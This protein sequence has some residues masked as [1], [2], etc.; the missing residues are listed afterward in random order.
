M[1]KN[2]EIEKENNINGK[3]T[4]QTIIEIEKKNKKKYNQIRCDIGGKVTY[5]IV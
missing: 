2:N 3:N 5:I 1:K 4:K